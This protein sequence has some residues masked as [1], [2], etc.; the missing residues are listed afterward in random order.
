MARLRPIAAVLGLM[1][2]AAGCGTEAAAT[3]ATRVAGS[4]ASSSGC[5]LVT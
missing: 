4:S 5:S 1:V 2:F 3:E